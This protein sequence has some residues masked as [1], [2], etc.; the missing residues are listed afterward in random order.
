M[1]VCVFSVWV[2]SVCGGLCVFSVFVYSVVCVFNVWVFSVCG[3]LCVF[4][5]CVCFQNPRMYTRSLASPH[6]LICVQSSFSTT[7]PP[8]PLSLPAALNPLGGDLVVTLRSEDDPFPSPS[9]CPPTRPLTPS[10][11]TVTVLTECRSLLSTPRTC[12]C[13]PHPCR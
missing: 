1:C 10:G 11:V 8:L 2:F 3:G 5:V 4:R 6:H 12:V 9:P 13:V 7:P